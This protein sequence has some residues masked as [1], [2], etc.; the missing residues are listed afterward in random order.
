MRYVRRHGQ[1]AFGR[2]CLQSSVSEARRFYGLLARF[3]VFDVG[4]VLLDVPLVTTVLFSRMI[5]AIFLIPILIF[6]LKLTND[7]EIM[8][9][10]ANGLVRKSNNGLKLAQKKK[11]LSTKPEV[12]IF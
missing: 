3:I 1:F 5:N 2:C 10:Y 9:K 6:L 7:E 12:R 11:G 8:G 4:S